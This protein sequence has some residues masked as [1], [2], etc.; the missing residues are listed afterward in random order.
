VGIVRLLVENGADVKARGVHYGTPLQAAA[1]LLEKGADVNAYG[2]HYGHTLQAASEGGHQAVIPLL[3]EHGA[4]I[5]AKGAMKTP[6]PSCRMIG[7]LNRSVRRRYELAQK[8]VQE[9]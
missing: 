5:N 7:Q 6:L 4:H 2:G 9:V 1:L 8:L 3:I